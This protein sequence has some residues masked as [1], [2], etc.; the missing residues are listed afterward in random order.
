M[1]EDIKT[2]QKPPQMVSMSQC[3]QVSKATGKRKAPT[4]N[5]YEYDPKKIEKSTIPI[6]KIERISRSN[7]A[8]LKNCQNSKIFI[9]LN[10]N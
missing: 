2:Q 7:A 3:S 1:K 6:F 9:E 5:H 10:K 8:A 4:K